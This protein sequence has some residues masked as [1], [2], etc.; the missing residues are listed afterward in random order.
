MKWPNHLLVTASFAQS[1]AFL[2]PPLTSTTLSQEISSSSQ[3]HDS[4]A[5]TRSKQVLEVVVE[6]VLRPFLVSTIAHG[7]PRSWE[8]FWTVETFNRT[9]AQHLVHALERLGPTYVKF[10]QA[11]S[12]RQ[13]VVPRPLADALEKLQHDM[14]PFDNDEARDILRK[15]LG[16]VLSTEQLTAF[17]SSLS[18][19]PVAAASI[20]QVYKGY[21]PDRG[22]V[23]VKI[24]RPLVRSVVEQ[25]SAMLRQ[26]AT[27]VEAIPGIPASNQDSLIATKLVAAV[28]EFMARV[29]EE[30]DYQNEAGNMEKFAELYCYRNG[31]FPDVNV[32]VPILY[33]DLCTSSIL[34]MEWIEGEKLSSVGNSTIMDESTR[35]ENLAMVEAGIA[36]T[37]SQLLGTGLMHADPHTGNLLK[38]QT[39]EGLLLGFLDFGML[40]TVPENV[41]DALVCAVAQLVFARDTQAVADLFGEL[42]LIP[43]TVMNDS[44]KRLALAQALDAVFR[45]ILLYPDEA[46][47]DGTTLVP[48]LRFDKLLAG[49]S[50]LVA[51]FQFTLPPYF[52]NNARALGTLEG[53]ARK[54]DP[55]FNSLQALYPYALN[56]ILR[57]PK[58]RP[59]SDKKA[60]C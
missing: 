25:D 1:L 31:I 10:G 42:D 9:N 15:E 48:V 5:L 4:I 36:A 16:Q 43:G 37:L 46:S 20:G 49:L 55:S 34:V 11:L 29:M 26:I 27:W 14:A 44:T 23:A 8:H 2:P 28:D 6:D 51:R 33:R 3:L 53:L 58:V 47:T 22:H 41:R 17:L 12:T 32:V 40:S 19:E 50:L 13:D 60:A 45:D 39:D 54:L 57:N 21:L 24:Q 18:K 35:A 38:V 30:L 56:R 59:R 52:L 7:I